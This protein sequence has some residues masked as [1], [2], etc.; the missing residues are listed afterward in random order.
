MKNQGAPVRKFSAAAVPQAW[1]PKDEWF[2]KTELEAVHNWMGAYN[3]HHGGAWVLHDYPMIP[4]ADSVIIR[5]AEKNCSIV[6]AKLAG[7]Q[8][9]YQ[10]FSAGEEYESAEFPKILVRLHRHLKQMTPEAFGQMPNLKPA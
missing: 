9:L 7:A 4:N 1:A 8:R 5:N 6:I 10:I 3:K 2:T